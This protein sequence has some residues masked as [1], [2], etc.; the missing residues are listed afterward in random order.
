MFFG[1]ITPVVTSD[2]PD[3]H[4]LGGTTSINAESEDCGEQHLPELAGM[5]RRFLYAIIMQE[6]GGK[7][8]PERGDS[9]KAWGCLQIHESYWK[10]AQWQW[11]KDKG[12]RDAKGAPL[13]DGPPFYGSREDLECHDGWPSWYACSYSKCIFGLYMKRWAKKRWL[14]PKKFSPAT[15]AALH[16]MGRTRTSQG[17]PWPET[18]YPP[19]EQYQKEVKEHGNYTD[20]E[21]GVIE[22][23]DL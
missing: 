18:P 15:I 14:D 1:P 16:R 23:E 4:N 5:H 10:D 13:E 17:P 12:L 3:L 19:Q 7:P 2:Y 11:R 6:S 8:C 20:E 9:G 21:W 22:W